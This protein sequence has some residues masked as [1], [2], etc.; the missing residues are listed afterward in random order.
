MDPE[1]GRNETSTTSSQLSS[2]GGTVS[3]TSTVNPTSPVCRPVIRNRQPGT[4]APQSPPACP[5]KLPDR[6][7]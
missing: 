4:A 2:S 6:S 5:A 3:C 7:M 1:A